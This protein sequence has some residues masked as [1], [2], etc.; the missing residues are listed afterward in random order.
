MFETVFYQ[1]KQ[2]H[3]FNFC[4]RIISF[5]QDLNTWFAY[6]AGRELAPDLD[7]TSMFMDAT[8]FRGNID[9]WYVGRALMSR[10]LGN[11]GHQADGKS[12]QHWCDT[13]GGEAIY[14]R[15]QGLEPTNKVFPCFNRP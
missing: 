8:A 11:S 12:F 7:I 6:A 10:A 1:C 3:G 5:N 14:F 15:K 13:T 2:H 9:G 4:G